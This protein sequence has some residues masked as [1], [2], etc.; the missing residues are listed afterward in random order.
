MAPD[1]R[2]VKHGDVWIAY[3]VLGNG[4]ID[5]AFCPGLLHNLELAWDVPAIAAGYERLASFSRLIIFDPRGCG[6]SDRGQPTD[7]FEERMDDMRA[8]LDAVGS[9]Q[10]ALFGFAIA[11]PL[12]VLFAATYPERASAL[13]QLGAF[14]KLRQ[15]LTFL[16]RV[17]WTPDEIMEEIE[18]GWGGPVI[19]D[20]LAPSLARNPVAR[21]QWA[22]FLRLTVSPTA[23]MAQYRLAMS[24]DVTAA[25]S[26]IRVP[27]LVLHR[28]GD[29]GVDVENGR[30]LAARISGAKFVELPGDDQAWWIGDTAAI[31]DEVEEFLTGVRPAP[32]PERVLA[33][34]LFTD[35]VGS[36]SAPLPWAT[37][38]GHRSSTGTTP[39]RGT[40]SATTAA[41]R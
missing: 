35:I 15:D 34:V 24:I 19:W 41:A 5:L 4:P 9:K 2:Y 21:Q 39:R 8:V 18:R 3:Q 16:G 40:S 29:Q 26:A 22:R 38:H 30:E 20:S 12:P 33:T 36:P 31:I 14:A 28:S 23:F 37:R 11:A 32:K 27:T 17:P 10:A 1:T 25:T 6:L 7:S 13:I